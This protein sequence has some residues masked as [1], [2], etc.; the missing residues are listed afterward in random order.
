MAGLP[1]RDFV[2]AFREVGLSFMLAFGANVVAALRAAPAAELTKRLA[3][4]PAPCDR[5]EAS[6]E[7]YVHPEDQAPVP[8]PAASQ[9]SQAPQASLSSGQPAAAAGAATE[10]VDVAEVFGSAAVNAVNVELLAGEDGE[11]NDD[12]EGEGKENPK[13]KPTDE[14]AATAATAAATSATATATTTSATSAGTSGC[15]HCAWQCDVRTHL[16]RVDV[17]N[18]GRMLRGELTA[19][20]APCMHECAAVLK[21]LIAQMQPPEAAVRHGLETQFPSVW[22]VAAEFLNMAEARFVDEASPTFIPTVAASAEKGTGAGGCT[23]AGTGTGSATATTTASSTAAA[24]PVVT[25]V[26]SSGNSSGNSSSS[27]SLNT[28][29]C[30]GASS[31]NNNEK[32]DTA[33]S[34]PLSDCLCNSANVTPSCHKTTATATDTNTNSNSNRNRIVGWAELHQPNI[35]LFKNVYIFFE[36]ECWADET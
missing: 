4:L 14:A 32:D 17:P 23:G 13:D 10:P 28:A 21:Q 35:G 8:E 1:P 18:V 29:C 6:G 25:A 22:A 26:T 20:N 27:S 36:A 31:V 16:C 5:V 7:S 12:G 3:T 34:K 19:A 2:G 15:R 11:V 24:S 30:C 9:A 33:N